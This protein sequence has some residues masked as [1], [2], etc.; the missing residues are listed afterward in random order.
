M[1]KESYVEHFDERCR[2][3]IVRVAALVM[4]DSMLVEGGH[5]SQG[6]AVANPLSFVSIVGHCRCAVKD[7]SD[8]SHATRKQKRRLR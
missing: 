4:I 8:A 3:F 7:E 6:A 2:T 5:S 1:Q